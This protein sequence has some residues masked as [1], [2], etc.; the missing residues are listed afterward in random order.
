[1]SCLNLFQDTCSPAR[2]SGIDEEDE[3]DYGCESDAESVAS[4]VG[5]IVAEESSDLVLV[6]EEEEKK[7]EDVS[8]VSVC[9]V[10][11]HSRIIFPHLK[12]SSPSLVTFNQA[13]TITFFPS[14]GRNGGW[15]I[16]IV[17][18]DVWWTKEDYQSFRRVGIMLARAKADKLWEG[19]LW[20]LEQAAARSNNEA[21]DVTREAKS[22]SRSGAEAGEF[23]DHE[24][25]GKWWCK[26][27]HS[28]RGLEQLLEGQGAHRSKC[29][30]DVVTKVLEE[31]QRQRKSGIA[32]HRLI[33]ML[34]SK[35]SES[36]RRSARLIG[37]R[38]EEQAA[39]VKATAPLTPYLKAT[40]KLNSTESPVSVR[41]E[42]LDRSAL[43]DDAKTKV[44]EKCDVEF[45]V[46]VVS[47]DDGRDS[48]HN[49]ALRTMRGMLKL[50]GDD[51]IRHSVTK[52]Q[53]YGI[54]QGLLLARAIGN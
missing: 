20:G 36:S 25:S 40:K 39:A 48:T 14:V 2:S 37:R 34:A 15:W 51:S 17:C 13:T 22:E 29:V 1:M 28:R 30:K 3:N 18:D 45:K 46:H 44:Q 26:Y 27:G 21:K 54:E 49:D 50:E 5:M 16:P 19:E 4:K 52:T 43:F 31:Q 11:K 12:F 38:D 41:S 47:S 32:D 9:S 53:G 8:N 6:E 23:A 7:Q 35:G 33:A 10:N 42:P 24:S